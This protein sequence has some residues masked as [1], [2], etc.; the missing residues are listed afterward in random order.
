MN[1]YKTKSQLEKLIVSGKKL[2]FCEETGLDY[3]H[4]PSAAN[5]NV[6]GFSILSTGVG[7]D[8]RWISIDT[9]M[10]YFQIDVSDVAQE[11]HGMKLQQGIARLVRISGRVLEKVIIFNQQFSTVPIVVASFTGT[12]VGISINQR[13]SSVIICEN[14]AVSAVTLRIETSA[15]NFSTGN[16]WDANWLA[17]GEF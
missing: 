6:N 9:F 17:M 10:S 11:L 1:Y 15:S 12:T 4:V 3:Y 8:T 14:T 2:S 13:R 7:G 5:F 16:T